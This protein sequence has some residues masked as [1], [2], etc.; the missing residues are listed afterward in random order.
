[1][2][3][4]VWE[5]V[6][7]DRDNILKILQKDKSIAYAIS[8]I[9]I[10]PGKSQSLNK[11]EREK[12]NED[13]IKS[14]DTSKNIDIK[15]DNSKKI[16][17]KIRRSIPKGMTRLI[18]RGKERLD[19]V[20]IESAEFINSAVVSELSYFSTAK[21]RKDWNV[22]RDK[23]K[24]RL[25]ISLFE[26][27]GSDNDFYV[28]MMKLYKK[29]L[30]EGEL[31]SEY[32]KMLNRYDFLTDSILTLT[33]YPHIHIAIGLVSKDGEYTLCS[34]IYTKLAK[35]N[36]F[37]GKNDIITIISFLPSYNPTEPVFSTD[38]NSLS[39]I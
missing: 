10:H 3:G 24:I 5:S 26:S 13:I 4:T 34:E 8:S 38:Y 32:T 28:Y 20:K 17:S 12:L 37:D 6:N 22:K 33:G 25:I 30:I 39:Y 9:E 15:K 14:K 23:D 21:T 7:D 31:D 16:K 11:S 19:S 18:E 27:I 1:L 35:M 36:L 29:V 2:K